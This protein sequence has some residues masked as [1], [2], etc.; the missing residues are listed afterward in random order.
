MLSTQNKY[1]KVN[2]KQKRFNKSLNWHDLDDPGTVS[3]P[4]VSEVFL[5]AKIYY[6][7]SIKKHLI[8]FIKNHYKNGEIYILD[9]YSLFTLRKIFNLFLKIKNTE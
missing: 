9:S 6:E 7:Q 5:N 1:N 8:P 4:F 3:D 2:R